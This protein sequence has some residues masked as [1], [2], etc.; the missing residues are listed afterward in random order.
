M[1]DDLHYGWKIAAGITLAATTIFIVDNQRQ[2]INQA[3]IIEIVLGTHERYVA[4]HN[5]N[6]LFVC[7]W[8]SN[9]YEA[10][11]T[12]GVTNWSAVPYYEDVTNVIGTRINR[13]MLKEVDILITNL[14]PYYREIVDLYDGMTSMP[15][16]LTVTGLWADLSIGDGTNQFTQIPVRG[17]NEAVYGGWA[18]RIYKTALEER[19][20]VLNALKVVV[21]DE[22]VW[23]RGA[24]I[25]AAC[26][27]QGSWTDAKS[28]AERIWGDPT[29]GNHQ[30]SVV[31]NYLTRFAPGVRW[32]WDYG[33]MYRGI[34]LEETYYIADIVAH[35][36]TNIYL[37]TA[38]NTNTVRN[39]QF[40]YEQHNNPMV[41]LDWG[42]GCQT[43][44]PL[45]PYE[46]RGFPTTTNDVGWYFLVE[47]GETSASNI[48]ID[49]SYG[50]TDFSNLP[51][52]CGYPDY[53]APLIHESS[54]QSLW[55]AVIGGPAIES[56]IAIMVNTGKFN[57]CTNAYWE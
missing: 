46:A 24:R 55:F 27:W 21:Y 18:N 13:T 2:R 23:A 8:V 48:V 34:N 57:Y 25:I 49:V 19:Y 5:T 31:D 10:V 41:S 40:W 7:T 37:R 51:T 38:F 16:A 1:F 53:Y 11:V 42:V 39:L 9:D 47:S 20:K 56:A 14:I 22:K 17:T 32:G 28:E 43:P 36:I 4:V 52:A 30:A 54:T 6:P 15:Q 50:H 26:D 12:N 35:H 44:F 45:D 33:D 3:D 29:D